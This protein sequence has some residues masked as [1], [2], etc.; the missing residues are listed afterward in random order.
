[1]QVNVRGVALG[2]KHAARVMIPQGGG[3]CIISRTSVAP[4]AYTASM[5]AIVGLT[6]A[7]ELGRYGIRV[8]SISSLVFHELIEQCMNS[9]SPGSA[10]MAALYLASGEAKYVSGHNLFLDGGFSN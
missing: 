3:G 8:N 2:I 6:T 1:M 9:G 10:D 4:H 7:C 5:H